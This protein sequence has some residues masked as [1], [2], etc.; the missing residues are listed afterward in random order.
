[1][2]KWSVPSDLGGVVQ[3]GVHRVTGGAQVR[4]PELVLL[5][6]AQRGVAQALLDD[7]VE[8]GQQ[9]VESRPLVGGLAEQEEER[10]I[11]FQHFRVCKTFQLK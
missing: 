11:W 4:L 3:P 6:P 7:G 9:E 2:W 5:G 8:P 10:G 1:M